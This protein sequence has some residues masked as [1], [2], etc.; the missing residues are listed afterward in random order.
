MKIVIKL[1]LIILLSNS[2]LFGENVGASA[3]L[4]YYISKVE[5]GNETFLNMESLYDSVIKLCD[6]QDLQEAKIGYMIGKAKLASSNGEYYMA[7]NLYSEALKLLNKDDKLNSQSFSDK[8]TCMF[9]MG[10]MGI[11]LGMYDEST[12]YLFEL[13]EYNKDSNLNHSV[14]AYSV[15]GLLFLNINKM[16][17]GE[18]YLK[19]AKSIVDKVDTLDN[20]TL[21]TFY[22]SYSGLYY[23]K[24]EYDT[25]FKYLSISEN[26]GR[27]IND[28]EIMCN[29]YHNFAIIY[30]AI[31]EN[32]MSEDYFMRI[33][34]MSS[35]N[36][37]S[38]M[39]A[40]TMQNLAFLCKSQKE[41][42]RA[43]I[44]Y[45]KALEMADNINASK[46]KSVVLIEMSDLL[47]ENGEYQKSRDYLERGR[48]LKDSIFNSQ[49][50]DRITI[51]TNRYETRNEK[52]EKELL[53]QTLIASELK[54]KNKTIVLSILV[55][56]FAIFI[57]IVIISVNRLIKQRRANTML[58]ETINE[59]QKQ[60][61]INIENSK[62][63]FED[64]IED[65]NRELTTTAMCLIKA[66]E[67]L[68]TLKSEL[69]NL[70]E[71]KIDGDR[72][73]LIKEMLTILNGYN[74]EQGWTEFKLYFGQVHQSFFNNLNASN[75][76]LTNSE[77][78]TCALIVLNMSAKEI[79]AINN[80]SARTVEAMIY[81]IRKKM[82]IPTEVK[83]VN[84]LKQFINT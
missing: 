31:D 22:N 71:I 5:E 12:A 20:R 18:E 38:Y 50:M 34:Q 54:N 67:V 3:K 78:R 81:G 66:N 79:A 44:Y 19:K 77:Q 32:K 21:V 6:E 53:K 75:P 69:Q 28:N 56:A 52:T 33:L 2:N 40:L 70:L 1:I 35:E 80:R 82:N 8:K 29:I 47:Y 37:L 7:F 15:L 46:I 55:V 13:L 64:K 65:K 63:E 48:L 76:D 41:T 25:A 45:N 61:L 74:A 62:K 59:L 10:K 60:S 49:N 26:Y 14:N 36:D 27:K 23:F 4:K 73:K 84:Y 83:T 9:E 58:N 39:N 68:C 24:M 16:D 42:K 30:Q 43:L 72:K 57:A 17:T 11:N 51:L